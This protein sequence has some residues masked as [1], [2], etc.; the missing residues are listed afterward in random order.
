MFDMQAP[1]QEFQETLMPLPLT[2]N[3]EDVKVVK[4]PV[5]F[6]FK[7][8]KDEATGLVEARPALE[9]VL[10][11][12]SYEGIAEAYNAGGKQ[13]DL[14]VEVVR[15]AQIARA[16]EII[17][18][19]ENI[20]AEN[21]PYEQISWEAIANLAKAERKGGG[22]SKDQWEEFAADYLAS[23]PAITGKDQEKIANAV[24]IL[25]GKFNSVKSNKPVI[26]MLLQQLGM[27][28]TQAPNAE[29][30]TD[31][32]EFLQ[33]KATNLLNADDSALLKDLL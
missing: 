32:I 22:I 15:D 31:C 1:A 17:N 9:L 10:P 4:L 11:L 30:F 8:T 5:K 21:F 29:S 23:M 27:Y 6:R 13:L 33:N 7:K 19:R 16:R 20:D 28:A 25:V 26:K 14:L 18:E 3:P 24:K 12:L 2:P